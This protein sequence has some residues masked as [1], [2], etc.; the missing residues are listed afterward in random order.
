MS[1]PLVQESAFPVLLMRSSNSDPMTLLSRVLRSSPNLAAHVCV[2]CVKRQQ[3]RRR[4]RRSGKRCRLPSSYGIWYVTFLLFPRPASPRLRHPPSH[5]LLS[6]R[7]ISAG[8]TLPSLN[9][10]CPSPSAHIAPING[11]AQ[12]HSSVPNASCLLLSSLL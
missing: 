11:C 4:W 12:F 6:S 2:Y 10:R 1:N 8:R 7:L 5:S 9:P 3:V